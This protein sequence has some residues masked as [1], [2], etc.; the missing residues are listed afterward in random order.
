MNKDNLWI[1]SYIDLNE[2]SPSI[3]ILEHKIYAFKLAMNKA[4]DLLF[5]GNCDGSITLIDILKNKVI[6]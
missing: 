3:N 1:R 6:Q 4:G 5:S 2:V